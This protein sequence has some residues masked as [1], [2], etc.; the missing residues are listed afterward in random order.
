MEAGMKGLQKLLERR[1][2]LK[3][4]HIQILR[5]EIDELRGELKKM[6]TTPSKQK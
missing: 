6:E 4:Q 2:F 3:K 5:N 1:I